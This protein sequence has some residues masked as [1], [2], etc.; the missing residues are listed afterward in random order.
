MKF[1][2]GVLWEYIILRI[3]LIDQGSPEDQNQWVYIYIYI[4]TYMINT[5]L[6]ISEQI[7]WWWMSE[8]R[9]TIWKLSS[10]CFRLLQTFLSFINQIIFHLINHK[11]HSWLPFWSYDIYQMLQWWPMDKMTLTQLCISLWISTIFK[12]KFLLKYSWFT[13]FC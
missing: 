10:F 1:K 7:G 8:R 12:K 3:V 9:A 4:Y 11:S 13:V 2:Y 5:Q 6:P